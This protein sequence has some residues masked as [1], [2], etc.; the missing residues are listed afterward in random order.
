LIGK[1]S[2]V[3]EDTG[4]FLSGRPTVYGAELGESC[5]VGAD[6][7]GFLSALASEGGVACCQN[8]CTQTQKDWAGVG[9]LSHERKGGAFTAAGTC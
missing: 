8:R 7:K 3:G 1:V 4:N 2:E 5:N 9:V 6:C